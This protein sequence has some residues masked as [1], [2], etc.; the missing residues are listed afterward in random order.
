PRFGLTQEQ[1]A[2]VAWLVEHH[3]TMSTVAQQRDLQD[4]KTILDFA[5]VVQ[6]MER[7]KLLLVLTIVVI[8]AVGPGVWNGWKGQLLR[9]LYWE[10]EPILT[11]GHSQVSRELRVNRARAE[12]SAALGH[13]PKEERERYV[14][15]HYA[16]YL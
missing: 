2:T 7:L 8:R 4:H 1:T 13:W 12:L 11:G 9:T 14:E 6:D 10:A 3:L 16:P 5:A 15:R